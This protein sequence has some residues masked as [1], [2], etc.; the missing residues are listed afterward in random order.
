MKIIITVFIVFIAVTACQNT[1]KDPDLKVVNVA[2]VSDDNISKSIITDT[3]GDQME[4]IKNHTKNTIT[5]HLEGKTYQLK[6]NESTP[7][8]STEDNKYLFTETKKEVTFIKKEVEMVLFHS[9]N[10]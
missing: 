7:G 3:Y 4:I 8:F 10:N 2:A 6:K 9:K 1:A 5:L